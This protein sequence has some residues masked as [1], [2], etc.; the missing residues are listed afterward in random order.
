MYNICFIPYRQGKPADYSN[1]EFQIPIVN[2]ATN[3]NLPYEVTFMHYL[4]V[5]SSKQ[6]NERTKK[7]LHF[8]L[9]RDT[10]IDA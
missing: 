3:Q 5:D 2:E 1:I 10:L 4:T 8:Q 7:C 9:E 6:K